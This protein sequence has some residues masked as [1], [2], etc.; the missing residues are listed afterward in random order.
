MLGAL[1]ILNLYKDEQQMLPNDISGVNLI[2]ESFSNLEKKH[3]KYGIQ[4]SFDNCSFKRSPT[5]VLKR[6]YGLEK[7]KSFFKDGFKRL[8][9]T[10]RNLTSNKKSRIK[11]H[12]IST[13]RGPKEPIFY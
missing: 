7:P 5:K 12:K 10:A 4:S 6:I 3:E 9:K 2:S 1:R 8:N 13:F 11:N